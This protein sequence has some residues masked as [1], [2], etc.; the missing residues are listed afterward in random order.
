MSEG[1]PGARRVTGDRMSLLVKIARMYHEQ[2]LRQPEIAARLH[3]SQSRV[4]RF[5]KEAG[6][7]GIVRTVVVPPPG[8]FS[9]LEEAVQEKYG[10]TDVVVAGPSAEDEAAVLGPSA[11]W[12]PPTW[13]PPCSAANGW[14]S[15]PGRPRCSRSWRRWHPGPAAAP[16]S[17]CSCSAGWATLR[18]RCVPLGSP[19][20]C[21][22]PPAVRRCTSP[23]QEWWPPPWCAMRCWPIPTSPTSLPPGPR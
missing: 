1:S 19:T 22:R 16:R 8:T 15:P 4:S 6:A 14:G 17:W 2:G 7:L 23:H 20:G 9:E 21:P 18:R 13:R 3:I 5:L 10:L 11:G 12:V